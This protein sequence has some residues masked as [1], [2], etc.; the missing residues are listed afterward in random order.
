MKLY[1]LF[2]ET[3]RL[4]GV[5]TGAL[6][7]DVQS[8]ELQLTDLPDIS[9]E[10]VPDKELLAIS[11]LL[12]HYPD[13]E[14]LTA[15]FEVLLNAHA[16]GQYTNNAF[17]AANSDLGRIILHKTLPLADLT[18]ET[19]KEEVLVFLHTLK[20]WGD[21]YHNGELLRMGGESAPLE[22]GVAAGGLRV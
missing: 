14:T 3:G 20:T 19:L 15:L 9:L 2:G 1:E 17:F 16:Y 22:Q 10:K 5:E 7:A 11:G 4:L 13:R 6:G 12:C 8:V 21:A 18:P